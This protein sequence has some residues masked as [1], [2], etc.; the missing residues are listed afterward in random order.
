MGKGCVCGGWR[1]IGLEE[2]TEAKRTQMYGGQGN[3][4]R[5]LSVV[6]HSPDV[7]ALTD[8]AL[9]DDLWGHKFR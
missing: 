7:S 8:R 2:K 9:L 4:R 6:R 3:P 1:I 5:S